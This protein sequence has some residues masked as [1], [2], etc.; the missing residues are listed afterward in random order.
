MGGDASAFPRETSV[1][2]C[3]YCGSEA[4]IPLGRVVADRAAIRC[5][6]QCRDCSKKFVFLR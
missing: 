4:V 6:Y 3:P 1:R 2:R 5:D